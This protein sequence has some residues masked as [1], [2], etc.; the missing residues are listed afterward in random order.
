MSETRT[1]GRRAKQ[2][3]HPSLREQP[4]SRCSHHQIGARPSAIFAAR[5]R[6]LAADVVA[7]RRNA[8]EAEDSN[9]DFVT[10]ADNSELGTSSLRGLAVGR[11]ASRQMGLQVMGRPPNG[12]RPRRPKP[13]PEQVERG[14]QIMLN[15]I[16]C[17]GWTLAAEFLMVPVQRKVLTENT[18]RRV[19]NGALGCLK[20]CT[21]SRPIPPS[22]RRASPL[23][24]SATAG[25]ARTRTADSLVCGGVAT[26]AQS[27]RCGSLG[28][29]GNDRAVLRRGAAL[30]RRYRN[31]YG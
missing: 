16:G 8:A 14:R 30:A 7:K 12:D 19:V 20:P 3:H 1:F 10:T 6:Q 24:A 27:C 5:P 18:A 15:A 4:P 26:L 21:R 23:R 17:A 2:G 28:G 9:G 29:V 13:T 31:A 11:E 22:T 25:S